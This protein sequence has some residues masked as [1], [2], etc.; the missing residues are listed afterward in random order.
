M[1]PYNIINKE[2]TA[3]LKLNQKDSDNLPPY[4]I[5]D[6]ILEM[7][8]DENKDL[9]SI[10][11]K[12]FKKGLVVKVWKMIKNSEFKRYQSAIGPK[13]TKMSL[14]NDRRFPITNKF[15]IWWEIKC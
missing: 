11:N 2:P 6:Q 8:I 15:E 3:E 9:R 5:L 10:I 1:I 7:L 13:L 12:G 14:A 4:K